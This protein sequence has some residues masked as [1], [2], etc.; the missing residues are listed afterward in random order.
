MEEKY[1]FAICAKWRAIKTIKAIANK[2]AKKIALGLKTNKFL[3][4]IE[5]YFVNLILGVSLKVEFT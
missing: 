4:K 1:G 2:S 3:T 5:I